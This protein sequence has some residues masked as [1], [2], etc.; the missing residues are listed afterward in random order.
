MRRARLTLLTLLVGCVTTT[1]AQIEE[2][3]FDNGLRVALDP[4]AGSDAVLAAVAIEAG[5]VD[6][7]PGKSGLAH[8]LEHLL[9]DGFDQ[10][11]ERGVTEAFERKSAYVN[12][13][14]RPHATV[15]LV[16][17]PKAEARSAVEFLLGM[18]SRSA[19]SPELVEKERKVILEE[20]AKDAQRPGFAEEQQRHHALWAG[21]PIAF[22]AGGR[23]ETV[24]QVTHHDVVTWWRQ[25]YRP[26]RARV[27]IAGDGT[28]DE[29]AA[30]GAPLAGWAKPKGPAPT[31]VALDRWAGW[32]EQEFNGEPSN[33]ATWLDAAVRLPNTIERADAERLAIWLNQQGSQATDFTSFEVAHHVGPAEDWLE[34]RVGSAANTKQMVEALPHQLQRLVQAADRTLSE[35]AAA[36]VIRQH[37]HDAAMQVQRIHYL[38]VIHGESLA[39]TRTSLAA[40]LE[41]PIGDTATLSAAAAQLAKLEPSRWRF[42][43]QF[44]SDPSDRRRIAT[45]RSELVT[46]SESAAP[47]QPLRE[48]LSIRSEPGSSVFAV[49]ILIPDRA[50]HELPY[51][52]GTVDLLHRVIGKG[53]TLSSPSTL[54]RRLSELGVVLK[55]ADDASIPFDDYYNTTE[56]GYIR[57]EGPA[58]STRE[59]LTLLAEMIKVP[60][61][62]ETQFAAALENLDTA[63]RSE[64]R[65]ALGASIRLRAQ[66]LGSEH[67]AARSI[68][69][70]PSA[71]QPTSQ[72]LTQL[73]GR[74]PSGY[75][76]SRNWRVALVAPLPEAELRL[77][78]N[79]LFELEPVQ[80]ADP[81]APSA[82]APQARTPSEPA[83]GAQVTV[84]AGQAVAVDDADRAALMLAMRDLSDRMVAVIREREGLAYG[85]GARVSWLSDRRW[86]LEAT[87][88][89]RPENKQRV[90]E[91]LRQLLTELR[92]SP[93]S[94]DAMTR[95]VAQQRKQEMLD[96]LAA[97]SRAHRQARLLLEGIQSPLAI[98][99]AQL[100]QV[101]AED[102][103]R[104]VARYLTAESFRFL[105]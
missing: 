34:F 85:L 20:L 72:D 67:P 55:L 21:T 105:P 30:I 94:R 14:T 89:T 65:S 64:Q 43:V 28:I 92:S 38:A 47:A 23:P 101:T 5:S 7:P 58:A 74:W 3:R 22:G 26:D 53:T 45:T 4:V 81:V 104:V 18:L 32:G 48:R 80:N 91:L 88:G 54:Q 71:P 86:W 15:F 77:L 1:L 102:V 6:D 100:A 24:A 16:L 25:H 11:D 41:A 39:T 2:R 66:I 49:T 98:D 37:A 78:I 13:F 50:R 70:D 8:F 82:T 76:D 19:I 73:L 57:L 44:K 42:S 59:A 35:S 103:Q 95:L 52:A 51:P 56:Y 93:L 12:A 69:G 61:W 87:V 90:T 36:R 10:L 33:T 75:F 46:E 99:S 97:I 40:L 68:V 60:V 96:R 62:T 9:F 17:A 29:L 83:A 84:I 63:R 79:D 27:L 31:R